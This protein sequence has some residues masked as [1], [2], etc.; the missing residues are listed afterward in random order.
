MGH[1]PPYAISKGRDRAGEVLHE[2]ER[3]QK[4]LQRKNVHLYISG[5]HHAWYPSHVGSANL[6]SLGCMGSGPRQRLNDRTPPQQTITLLDLF[7]QQGEL[8]E[9]TIEL[10]G[11][12]VLPEQLLPSS[13]QP[14]VGPR[15]DLRSTRIN[16]N[17]KSTANKK[18]LSVKT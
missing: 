18:R 12:Q 4:L 13:L 10:D 2:P 8:V 14:S 15:L 3:L 16:L 1:L 9:T 11:L 6:L 7:S 5:H 17:N